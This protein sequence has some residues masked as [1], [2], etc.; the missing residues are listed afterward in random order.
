MAP[1]V[2]LDPEEIRRRQLE[3]KLQMSMA[4]VGLS[5]RTTNCLDEQGISTVGDLLK[6]KRSDLLNIPN[7]GEK[8]LE[9]VFGALEKLGF[10]RKERRKSESAFAPDEAAELLEK[11]KN[12][13]KQ[14]PVD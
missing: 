2:P 5:V 13:K 7:F 10:L 9:E 14:K 3:E 1:R 11:E 6:C 12:Q 4:E 8:T